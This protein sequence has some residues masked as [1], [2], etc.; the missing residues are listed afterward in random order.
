MRHRRAGRKLNRDINQRKALFKNLIS[1]LVLRGKI[2]TTEAKAR[3]IRRLVDKLIARAKQGTVAARRLIAAFLPDKQVVNKLV[4]EVAPNLKQR[5]SGFTAL[6]RIERRK[7]DN[8][9]VVEV[10]LLDQVAKGAAEPVKPANLKQVTKPKKV[11]KVSKVSKESKEKV[12]VKPQVRVTTR[13][14]AAIQK[15]G[16]GK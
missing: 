12:K 2:R 8:A 1:A 7:G 15:R 6:T 16:T 9:V 4:D 5:S 11:S 10:E 13:G 3:A 14:Q